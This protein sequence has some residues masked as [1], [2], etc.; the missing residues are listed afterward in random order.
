MLRAASSDL[1]SALEETAYRFRSARL[2]DLGFPPRER[3]MEIY[4]LEDPGPG[5]SMPDAPVVDLYMPTSYA[6]PP[7]AR[8][9]ARGI[10]GH[11]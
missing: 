11:R 1:T 3:A 9:P 4:G 7:A 8:P 10:A 2:E 6:P 5:A